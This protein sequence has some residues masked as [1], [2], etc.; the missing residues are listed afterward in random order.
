MKTALLA[1]LLCCLSATALPAG[2]V[3]KLPPV[4]EAAKDPSFF[5]FRSRLIEAVAAHDAGQIVSLLS[6]KIM[7][8]FGGNG[9]IDEFKQQW[10]PE[11]KESKLWVELGRVLSL[12]GKFMQDGG[13]AAPYYYAA[14][15]DDGSIDAFEW[16]AIV[17]ANIRVRE[18]ADANS[19]VIG[20]L[21]FELVR[22]EEQQD[23]APEEWT[24][25]KL[26]DGSKGFVATRFTGSGVGW[27]AVFDKENG[28][29]RMTAFVA[30]D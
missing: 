2:P 15:P 30:G 27:R 25:V 12:G 6:P 26:A 5:V 3:K 7:N 4:D 11:D 21:S 23:G 13:F 16:V 19:A 20:R 9:G 10:R 29:W 28:E 14:W 8:N 18:K 1:A 24:K 22:I 17:G